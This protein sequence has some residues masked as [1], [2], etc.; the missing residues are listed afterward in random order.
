MEPQLL[1]NY[2]TKM[3]KQQKIKN[4][5]HHSQTSTKVQQEERKMKKDKMKEKEK[6]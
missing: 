1:N 4:S 2:L 6:I 5:L 3:F